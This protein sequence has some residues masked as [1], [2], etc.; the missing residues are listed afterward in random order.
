MTFDPPTPINEHHPFIG[1]FDLAN[2]LRAHA[3][4]GEVTITGLWDA[5]HTPSSDDE[6]RAAFDA[7]VTERFRSPGDGA[8]WVRSKIRANRA[9]YQ[10]TAGRPEAVAAN[11]ILNDSLEKSLRHRARIDRSLDAALDRYD[12]LRARELP[13]EIPDESYTD[14]HDLEE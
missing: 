12:R 5:D 14:A 11:A 9:R 4:Q 3:F 6:W 1:W 8:A 2:Y 10:Q 7:M 13:Y